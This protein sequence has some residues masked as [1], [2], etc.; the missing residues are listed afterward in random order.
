M[1]AQARKY[2]API[3]SAMATSL[4]RRP[5]GIFVARVGARDILARTILLATGVIDEEP[6]LPNLMDSVQRGLIR[7]CG[8]CDAYEVIDHQVA[9]IGHGSTGLGEALFLRTYTSDITLFS[10]GR[11]LGLS[12]DE[13]QRAE[14]AGI[15][16]IDE[17]VA[18]VIVEHGRIRALRLQSCSC[19]SF[20]TLYSALGSVARSG[21]ARDLGAVLGKDGCVV[22]DQ[23]QRSSVDGL[24]VAGDVVLSLDQISVAMG[25][26]A[27]AATTIHNRLRG[28][29]M[30]I[31]PVDGTMSAALMDPEGTRRDMP[32]SAMQLVR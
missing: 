19:H 10:L 9:V 22:T 8:I 18:E 4:E 11:P 21:L 2:G 5:D 12:H 29:T 25:E 16:L 20:D 3:L 17:T 1:R 13:L 24:F 32:V 27:I 7:H 26:A 28:V 30:P 6:E 14:A 23:H 31:T 15:K